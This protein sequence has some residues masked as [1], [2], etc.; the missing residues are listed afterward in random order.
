MGCATGEEDVPLSKV[1]ES[2]EIFWLEENRDFPLG[3]VPIR[4]VTEPVGETE[5]EGDAHEEDAAGERTG[6]EIL[7]AG[8]NGDAPRA[9]MG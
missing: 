7:G 3:T 9:H 6:E 8:F 5:D 1:P 2:A 4:A